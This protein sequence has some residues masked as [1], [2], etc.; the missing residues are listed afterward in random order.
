[1]VVDGRP[2][3][4]ADSLVK[5]LTAF[6]RCS[7]SPLPACGERSR[8]PRKRPERVRGRL[9]MLS[10]AVVP[11]TRL[12]LRARHPLPVN[13]ER[14]KNSVPAT[15][16]RPG[17]A[18]PRGARGMERRSAPHQFKLRPL[19]GRAPSG[20]PSRRLKPRAALFRRP[21]PASLS[22]KLL[23][24][25][26]GALAGKTSPTRSARPQT[27]PPG[28]AHGAPGIACAKHDSGRRSRSAQQVAPVA[29][30]RGIEIGAT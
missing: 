18:C 27:L 9:D 12:A 5:Q 15:P 11:L 17:S 29:P 3:I 6:G 23:A 21:S 16:A 13:G 2:T 20:A 1:L 4:P 7:S 10:L 25:G 22:A 26:P 30:P 19:G 14:E 28:G 24:G 8:R